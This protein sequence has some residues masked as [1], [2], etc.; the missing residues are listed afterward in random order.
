MSKVEETLVQ[1]RS[2][3]GPIQYNSAFTQLVMRE[4]AVSPAAD[5]LTDIH[6]EC[7]HMIIHKISRIIGGDP[8]HSDNM[9]DI[10][11]Y[12][13]LLENY[14]LGSTDPSTALTKPPSK[15]GKTTNAS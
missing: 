9:H 11:G 12:A 13:T 7:L 8:F 10:A 4:I 3:Y 1:R 15:K 5:E 14:V 2:K 6:I